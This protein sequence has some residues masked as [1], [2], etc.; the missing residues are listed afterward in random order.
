MAPPLSSMEP[1]LVDS[2]ARV[3]YVEMPT[4]CPNLCVEALS[5]LLSLGLLVII[6]SHQ[7]MASGLI[8]TLP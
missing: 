5:F 1:R 8:P 7:A 2:A 6:S 3:S 4:C